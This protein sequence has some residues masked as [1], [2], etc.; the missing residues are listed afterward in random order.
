MATVLTP[1][2]WSHLA[3]R[4][5]S[6]VKQPKRRAGCA[7][8]SGLTAAPQNPLHGRC[9]SP[10]RPGVRPLNRD[11]PTRYDGP[12]PFL[13][14]RQPRTLIRFRLRRVRHF[15]PFA[16]SCWRGA[17]RSR[18]TTYSLG[19]GQTA[20]FEAAATQLMIDRTGARPYHGQE[21]ANVDSAITCDA[22]A[23]LFLPQA[24]PAP[25]VVSGSHD[26]P[27]ASRTLSEQKWSTLGERRGPNQ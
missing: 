19:W 22:F 15:L 11:W 13:L 9:R 1:H 8:R 18:F 23:D 17:A 24:G 26:A 4:C 21:R 27:R 2:S 5:R 25:Q 7:S 14:P 10:Q 6:S 20:S 16:S 3:W 12:Y